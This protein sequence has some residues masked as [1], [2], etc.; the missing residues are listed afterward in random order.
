MA[1]RD[2]LNPE[3]DPLATA[4]TAICLKSEPK[5]A[6]IATVAAG[7]AKPAILQVID[8]NNEFP[9]NSRNSRNSSSNATE[10]KKQGLKRLEVAAQGLPVTI[11]ELLAFFADDLQSFGSGEVTQAG[12]V[13]AVRWFVFQH[14]GRF[15][16]IPEPTP[17]EAGM[18]RCVDCLQD[19]C[20]YRQ[21]TPYGN[22]VMQSSIQ[23]RWCG[24]YT[25]KVHHLDDYRKR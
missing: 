9:R 3:Y 11:G 21:V 16:P 25:A 12:I 2:W 8:S 4:N 23:W 13:K 17:K 1:L 6:G 10:L 20:S 19:R 7:I 14:L 22:V 18:V 24:K 5:I 15:Q